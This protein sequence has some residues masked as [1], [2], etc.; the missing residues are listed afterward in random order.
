M[1]PEQIEVNI[2]AQSTMTGSEDSIILGTM[3]LTLIFA[4][5]VKKM[6]ENR[7]RVDAAST[8]LSNND[9]LSKPLDVCGES[10]GDYV[11]QA[12]SEKSIMYLDVEDEVYP[13]HM[14]ENE[15]YWDAKEM[16]AA[17][18]LT[19]ACASG[20]DIPRLFIWKRFHEG[21]KAPE[22]GSKESPTL[23]AAWC[24]D[25]QGEAG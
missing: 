18:T 3:I 7:K 13:G 20:A 12:V 21:Q 1:E 4:I 25:L 11:N 15:K 17:S 23:C 2:H 16:P 19:L 6:M 10:G 22:L 24:A 14:Q 8:V 5:T 9:A